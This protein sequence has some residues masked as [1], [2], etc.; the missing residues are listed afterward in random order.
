MTP[1]LL[2]P[3]FKRN[4]VRRISTALPVTWLLLNRVPHA[5][6]VE[7]GTKNISRKAR[8]KGKSSGVGWVGWVRTK[9]PENHCHLRITP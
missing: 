8:R 4:M 9:G 5:Q 2:F 6:P 1:R 3:I 7:E